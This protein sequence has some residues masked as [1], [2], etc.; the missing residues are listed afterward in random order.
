MYV[1]THAT[2]PSAG[3]L[4]L[5]QYDFQ[6]NREP[7][8]D[9]FLER[10]RVQAVQ[11]KHRSAHHFAL[12]IRRRARFVECDGLRRYRACEFRSIIADLEVEFDPPP[13]V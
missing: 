8:T 6:Q 12:H 10:P 7:F 5:A 3:A 2:H 4:T 11:P 1:G 9:E 13:A